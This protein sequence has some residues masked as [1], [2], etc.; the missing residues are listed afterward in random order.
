VV[1]HRG[2]ARLGTDR[3]GLTRLGAPGIVTSPGERPMGVARRERDTAPAE[4]RRDSSTNV[5]GV[6]SVA[7]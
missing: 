3:G 2:P 1:G 5:L 7:P 4:T 6:C